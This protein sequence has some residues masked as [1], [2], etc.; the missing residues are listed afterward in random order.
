M[1]SFINWIISCI[2]L[3]SP[4]VVFS[5]LFWVLMGHWDSMDGLQALKLT[6]SE[7]HVFIQGIWT[8]P[9]T[10]VTIAHKHW[11]NWL[12]KCCV[13]HEGFSVAL[14]HE[15]CRRTRGL[16]RVRQVGS[17][18]SLVGST[19]ALPLAWDHYWMSYSLS[20]LIGKWQHTQNGTWWVQYT[21]SEAF[22]AVLAV[23]QIGSHGAHYSH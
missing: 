9:P 17:V 10:F 2:L 5:V 16:G 15:L 1:P 20:F 3:H 12:R 13:L 4:W 22:P 11:L 8:L 21:H 7:T 14:L 19:L 18:G 6:F 23:Q